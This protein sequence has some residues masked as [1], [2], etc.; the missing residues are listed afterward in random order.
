MDCINATSLRRK[1]GQMGHPTFVAGA[2]NRVIAVPTR[3]AIRLLPRHA[4]R[5]APRHAGT[6]GMTKGH[7]HAAASV[8]TTLESA[9][10]HL[11]SRSSCGFCRESPP[12]K[13]SNTS[14]A[15]ESA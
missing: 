9:R 10:P 12:D 2:E 6:D 11:L 15:K 1:S 7:K 14:G 5:Y 8:N 13:E 3:A 4:P